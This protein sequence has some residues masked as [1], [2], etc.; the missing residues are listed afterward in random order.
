MPNWSPEQEDALRAVSNW[1]NDKSSP[2]VF[3]I[4]GYAGTGKTTI[5]REFASG[6]DGTVLFGAYTGKAAHVLQTKGCV[7]ARTIH[8]LIYHGREAS[9]ARLKELEQALMETLREIR[10]ELPDEDKDL[11]NEDP[12]VVKLR[13]EIDQ[14]RQNVAK[15]MFT[16][17]YESDVK[18]AKLVIIDE[19]SMVDAQMAEDLLFFGTK[20]LVLGDPAQLPPVMGAGY[21]VKDKP[22]IM[23]TEIHRQAR[24]NPIIAMAS[25]VRQKENLDVGTWGE[26]RIIALNEIT[27]ELV[28]SADQLLVGKN[29][30]RRNYNRRMRDLLF[31]GH[32]SWVPVQGEK[33][34]CLRN[35]HGIGLLNG[36]QWTCNSVLC[37]DDDSLTATIEP[38]DGGARQDVDIHSHHLKGKIDPLPWW[39]RKSAEEFDYGYAMTTHKAQGSQWDDVIVFDES[40][41]FRDDRYKWLYTAITRAAERVT[42]VKM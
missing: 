34:V 41:C 25:K 35:N 11:A 36:A 27:P 3:R 6:I 16:L 30:T 22:D 26:S 4:F 31:P 17:N 1:L 32:E 19:C 28:T 18:Y 8:S 23:L 40:F 38:F 13:A 39:D 12:A 24:D 42:V 9:A 20:I 10:A 37:Y 21:F 2:Q 7:G 5:A 33:L 14:E 29:A 15:P